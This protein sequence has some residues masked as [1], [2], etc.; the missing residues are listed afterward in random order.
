MTSIIEQSSFS[1]KMSEILQVSI[2]FNITMQVAIMS[3]NPG[4]SINGQAM[5]NNIPFVST[6]NAHE[7]HSASYAHQ[8]TLPP[9]H[10]GRSIISLNNDRKVKF[11]GPKLNHN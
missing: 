2:N 4:N 10:S 6:A 1:I 9:E 11:P 5:I 8:S 7:G 3:K